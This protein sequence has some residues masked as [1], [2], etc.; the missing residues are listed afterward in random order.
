MTHIDIHSDSNLTEA[1]SIAKKTAWAAY[2]N[3]RTIVTDD[4]KN[5]AYALA[6]A[7]IKFSRG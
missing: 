3:N 1:L 6:K 5:V 7:G 4:Y 2:V